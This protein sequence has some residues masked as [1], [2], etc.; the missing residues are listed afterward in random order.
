MIDSGAA[1]G[2][3]AEP[4]VMYRVGAGAY[5]RRG[6]RA[7]WR[8]EL[9]LQRELRRIRFT[10]RAEFLRNVGVRGLYRFVPEPIRKVAYRRFIARGVD[11]AGAPS[12]GQ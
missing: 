3:L 9:A 8:S 5:A 1:V 12:S 10:T 7:Q 2:N 6:G 4:L 11:G